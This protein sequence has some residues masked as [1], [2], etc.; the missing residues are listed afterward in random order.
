MAKKAFNKS[1]AE[2][3]KAADSLEAVGSFITEDDDDEIEVMA[4]A[5]EGMTFENKANMAAEQSTKEDKKKPKAAPKKK[6]EPVAAEPKNEVPV[7]AEKTDEVKEPVEEETKAVKKVVD[8]NDIPG[9]VYIPPLVARSSTDKLKSVTQLRMTEKTA[10]N[11]EDLA[12]KIKRSYNYVTN[13][14]LE[15][16]FDALNGDK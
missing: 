9:A 5:G 11:I 3:K 2:M 14:I 16:Y 12:K 13:M 6:E 10:K 15:A 1:K 7:K 4:K 8:I